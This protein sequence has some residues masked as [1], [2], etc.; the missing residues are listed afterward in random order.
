[1]NNDIAGIDEDPIARFETVDRPCAITRFLESAREV[2]GDRADMPLRPAIGDDD[3]V[4]ERRAAGK[5]NR[6][7]VFR[8]VVVKRNKNSRQER[9]PSVARAMRRGFLRRLQCAGFTGE[10]AFL[11]SES[12]FC[13]RG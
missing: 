4:R 12:S 3:P 7:R 1:M 9:L 8:L 5:L 13:P 6:H 11:R 2:L 10:N